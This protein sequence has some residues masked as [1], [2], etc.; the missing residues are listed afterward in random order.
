MARIRT[1]KPEFWDDEKIAEIPMQARL[2]FIGIWNFADDYGFI[3][4]SVKWIKAKVFPYDTLR[5]ADVQTWL[6]ALCKHR[7]LVRFGEDGK[8]YYVIRRFKDHQIIDKR[9][10][11]TILPKGTEVDKVIA[12]LEI[13]RATTGSHS[14]DAVTT[15]LEVES[16]GNVKGKEK[17]GIGMR[18]QKFA[19]T[20]EPFLE[21]YGKEMLNAFYKYWT[22]HG[23][24]DKKF[25]REK[26]KSWDIERR[27]QTWKSNESKFNN[28]GKSE[29]RESN[30]NDLRNLNAG[31]T[32][33]LIGGNNSAG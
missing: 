4:N 3:T 23:P 14:D 2:L 8:S 33:I 12:G 22:E 21:I 17:E 11:K 30:T 32:A 16:I 9:Y 26:E 18:K 10:T 15:P 5:D 29:K 27:L 6:D 25:R 31:A 7:F 1:I 24:D 28:N 20:L 19:S 13:D